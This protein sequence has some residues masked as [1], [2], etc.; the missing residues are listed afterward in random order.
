MCS[1]PSPPPPPPPPPP[2]ERF[3]A[4]KDL[5]ARLSPNRGTRAGFRST[6]SKRPGGLGAA[7]VLSGS[8]S[9]EA[10]V[11]DSVLAGNT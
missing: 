10:L 8:L 3:L 1:V 2:P 7:G 5:E 11:R 6:I 9:E 4:A